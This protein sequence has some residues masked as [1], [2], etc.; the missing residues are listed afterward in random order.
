MVVYLSHWDNIPYRKVNV[1]WREC[2]RGLVPTCYSIWRCGPT[3]KGDSYKVLQVIEY[4]LENKYVRI[5][6][7]SRDL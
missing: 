2:K 4:K 3:Y 5:M 7:F 1:V 6:Y